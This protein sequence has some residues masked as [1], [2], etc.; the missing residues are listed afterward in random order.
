MK[1]TEQGQYEKTLREQDKKLDDHKREVFDTLIAEQVMHVLGHP[2]GL[3]QVQ[4][5]RLW[6]DHYR[7]NIF[8]GAGI[9]SAKIVNSYFL[10]TDSNGNIVSAIPRIEKQY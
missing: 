1:S 7:V 5:R 4:V 6:E 10:T 3:I 2:T 9:T 8:A